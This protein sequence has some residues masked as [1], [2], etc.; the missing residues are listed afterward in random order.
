[1]Y[2]GDWAEGKRHGYGV[3][4]KIM[5]DGVTQILLYEGDWKYGKPEV[6]F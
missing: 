3:L 5:K 6:Y 4:S 2:E 1:M